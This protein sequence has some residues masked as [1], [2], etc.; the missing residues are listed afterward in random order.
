MA[1]S[2]EKYK[3][4]IIAGSKEHLEE[5]KELKEGVRKLMEFL[6]NAEFFYRPEGADIPEHRT[7]GAHQETKE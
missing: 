1:T 3:A 4:Y 7:I 6:N 5:L 2:K